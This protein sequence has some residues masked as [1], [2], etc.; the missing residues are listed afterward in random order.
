MDSRLNH[1]I[2]KANASALRIQQLQAKK[3]QFSSA[4]PRQPR[5]NSVTFE[6]VSF[7]YEGRED[8]ALHK[9]S[10]H[11]P[12]GTV[13][14]LVG[15]SGAGK[16][17]AARL[18][19]RFWDVTAGSLRIGDVDVRDL[20]TQ[21]LMEHVSFVFQDTFLFKDT[22]AANIR[23][24]RPEAT[25]EEIEAAAKAAQIHDFITS[26]PDGYNTIAGE[27]GTRLSGG[28]RQRVTIARAILRNCPIVVLDEATAFADP[29]NE[30][31]IIDAMANL[32]QGKTVIIIAHRLATIQNVDQIVVLDQGRVCEAGRH[33]E[34]V[35]HD[36]VYARLWKKY[37][38]AQGWSLRSQEKE[39]KTL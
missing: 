19:P 9:V 36:G 11:A 27:R 35:A 26:L 24:G 22:I 10:F 18:I 2:R 3:L 38:Q 15:P 14:A 7:A 39:R 30:A 23:L 37:Q 33:E 13:T 34:L 20:E 6:N 32:M 4:F 12:Q 31:A 5:D 28:E 1:L 25:D 8:E 29:E 17:T 21:T 16:T